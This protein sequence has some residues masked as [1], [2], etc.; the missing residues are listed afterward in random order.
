VHICENVEKILDNND[1][2]RINTVIECVGKP[3]TI[4]QA[5]SLAGNKST[6]MMFGLTKPEETISVKPFE[7]F[8][9]EIALK[10]SFINPY[11]Q[12]RALE[13]I[14]SGKIDVESMIYKKI[15]L[16]K[17]PEILADKIERIKGKYVVEL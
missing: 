3:A 12:R 14:E 4:E 11:T 1:I 8:K 10:A 17:L 13:I 2:K 6:V 16:E 9:K 7:I 5:I 15:Q